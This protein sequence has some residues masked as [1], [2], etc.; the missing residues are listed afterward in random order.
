MRGIEG[1]DW[2]VTAVDYAQAGCSA[3]GLARV[4]TR[5]PTSFVD[6]ICE[7]IETIERVVA[8]AGLFTCRRGTNATWSEARPGSIRGRRIVREAEH[9]NIEGSSMCVRQATL[10][11]KMSKGCGRGKGQVTVQVLDWIS[12]VGAYV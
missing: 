11:G 1:R 10:P 5:T 12:I 8:A 6:Q 3:R 7:R 2:Y 4:I 9:S